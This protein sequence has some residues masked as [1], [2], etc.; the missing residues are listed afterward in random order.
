MSK[1]CTKCQAVKGFDSFK[2][3]P[4][5]SGGFVNWC[6]DC[7]KEYRAAHYQK[8]KEKAQAQNSAWYAAN[9]E[10]QSAASKAHYLKDPKAHIARVQKAKELRPEY[11]KEANKLNAR[12]R[13][14]ERID[15][16][17]RSRISSQFRYCLGTGKGGMTTAAMLGYSIQEL[18]AHLER[19][20]ARGMSWANMGD[21]HID[22]IVPLS[23]FQ[24]TAS[25]D[26]TLRQAW[27]L[28]NLRPLWAAENIKKKDS[29][30]FLL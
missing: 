10:K 4:R 25:D 30:E 17:L 9:K 15:V 20:F 1:Q 21:W 2:K 26:P 24:I 14:A 16:R 3:D 19:Q 27:A 22:H 11:Y 13:R 18:K 23:S 5:Y 6:F 28:P 12:K 8:N 7:A 29:R